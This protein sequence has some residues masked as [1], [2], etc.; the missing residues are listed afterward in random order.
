VIILGGFILLHLLAL[1][2]FYS[3]G[4]SGNSRY[5]ISGIGGIGILGGV[6]YDKFCSR[7]G[8]PFALV[9]VMLAVGLN[10]A[11][12]YNYVASHNIY[13]QSQSAPYIVAFSSHG[14][15]GWTIMVVSFMLILFTVSGLIYSFTAISARERE[16]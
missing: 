11:I 5:L 8:A 10:I 2:L 14:R 15:L 9:P 12:W 1:A 6:A 13:T 16:S 3:Q 4:G 7:Y